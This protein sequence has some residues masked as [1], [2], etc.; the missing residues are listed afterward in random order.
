MSSQ[1]MSSHASH[2]E[3]NS[4]VSDG[5]RFGIFFE[6]KSSLAFRPATSPCARLV[7]IVGARSLAPRVVLLR[8]DARL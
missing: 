3:Q 5:K 1:V 6:K 2:V 8:A 4:L 7:F